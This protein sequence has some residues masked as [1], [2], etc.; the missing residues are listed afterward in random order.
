M[1]RVT[2]SFSLIII[3]MGLLIF[4]LS[5]IMAGNSA[6]ASAAGS[7]KTLT[8]ANSRGYIYDRNRVPLV[9][10]GH[11]YVLAVNPVPDVLYA[12]SDN[13]L[14]DKKEEVMANLAK[15]LP[16]LVNSEKRL[17]DTDNIKCFEVP[18][19][20]TENQPAAQLIGYLDGGGR[21]GVCGLEKSLDGTLNF[22]GGSLSATFSVDSS[23]RALPG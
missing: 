5:V 23:G 16:V 17:A 19:R 22:M 10:A 3:L 4:R 8:A 9:N 7:G 12:L 11:K 1:K 2:R 18:V 20:Y 13:L 6:G 15:G 14:K 21:N